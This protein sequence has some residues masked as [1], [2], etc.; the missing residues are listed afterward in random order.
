MTVGGQTESR[1]AE[2][3]PN[4]GTVGRVSGILKIEDDFVSLFQQ[5]RGVCL[6]HPR[7]ELP[8]HLRRLALWPLIGR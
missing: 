2:R 6:V 8:F 5:I 7:V 1:V 4:L 3:N